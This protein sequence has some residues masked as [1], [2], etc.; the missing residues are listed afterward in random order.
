MAGMYPDNETV[1]MF[2]TPMRWPGMG[3]DG[4][5]TNGSFSDPDEKPSMIPAQTLNLIIDNIAELINKLGGAPSNSG[6]LQLAVRFTAEA[7]ARCAV[8]R[9]DN[10]RAKIAARPSNVNPDPDDI[11]RQGD[12]DEVNEAL[13]RRLNARDGLGGPLPPHDFGEAE[14]GQDALTEYASRS[15]W[16]D[17]GAFAWNTQDP[18]ASTYTADGVTH[19]AGEI[20]NAT[21]VRNTH[22]PDGK[23]PIN[24]RLTLTNT[25]NTNPAVFYWEDVGVDTVG[26]ASNEAAG[27][28]KGSRNILANPLTGEI[29]AVSYGQIFG[30]GRNL[31]DLFNV[32]TPQ[33]AMAVLR[34]KCN[35][36][37]I[38]DFWD[39]CV[40][41]YIDIPL[42]TVDG[43]S[44]TGT[45][46]LISG[47]NHYKTCAS[48]KAS[49]IR[50][51]TSCLLLTRSC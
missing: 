5:F 29:E 46:I 36:E 42:L 17:G 7:L 11:A 26:F 33:A 13:T 45:R 32:S 43:A 6:A 41:D 16:G 48:R 44:Y 50:K 22:A 18:C 20:F 31:L 23:N 40:G 3:S 8:A 39:L 24:H 10:G 47:F 27:I 35:G 38:P 14:P 2:G 51:T 49:G 30:G 21:W 25:P 28:V 1:N 9:D 19:A 34:S 4:K 12:L 37:G 15:I